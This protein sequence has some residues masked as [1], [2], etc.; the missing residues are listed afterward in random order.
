MS[1]LFQ[2][3]IA[4]RGL[5]GTIRRGV[6]V[7]NRYGASKNK[8]CENLRILN[9]I[10]K[11]YDAKATIPVTTRVL[12]HNLDI[13]H[14]LSNE[15]IEAA[16]HGYVH[17]DYTK[18]SYDEIISHMKSAMAICNDIGIRPHGFRAPY[19]KTNNE[20]MRA[21]KAVGLEYDSS[22]AICFDAIPKDS[23]HYAQVRG[24]LNMCKPRCDSPR[25][26]RIEGTLEI[27]VA[28][29]DDEMLVD[30]LN[31]APKEVAECWISALKESMD[32]DES[33]FVLQLHPERV[34]ILSDALV[35]V[36]EWANRSN[37]RIR[38]LSE[39]AENGTR[40]GSHCMAITG[41]I[42]IVRLTDVARR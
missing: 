9:H 10:L 2:E 16:I 17:I 23:E 37:V 27:P 25:P 15:R 29:P 22:Y 4:N 8:V 39:I 24:L 14:L 20:I 41:D 32:V 11:E 33:V 21:I 28:L 19:L 1:G 18:L 38:N 12:S 5:L 42:D 34:A 35:E 3:S 36:L 6:D 26:T 13:L 40:P 31:F 7:I 30:R